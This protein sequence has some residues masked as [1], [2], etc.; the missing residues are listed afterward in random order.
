MKIVMD[1]GYLSSRLVCSIEE[2]KKCLGMIKVLDMW[3]HVIS[4]AG[5]LAL[6]RLTEYHS[7]DDFLRRAALAAIRDTDNIENILI[8]YLITGDY[9]GKEF[10]ECLLIADGF[11]LICKGVTTKELVEHLRGWF[12]ADF[13]E[14]YD[15]EMKEFCNY[16]ELGQTR[17]SI[18][19]EF[20][21]LL[22][23]SEDSFVALCDSITE[24][25]DLEDVALALKGTN[26]QI[27]DR[28]HSN[29]TGYRKTIID[30]YTRLLNNVRRIDVEWAQERIIQKGEFLGFIEAEK[31][32]E[33]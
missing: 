13:S 6:E 5:L 27:C 4:G 12:G 25:D 11:P 3:N 16:Q 20:D 21:K 2:K 23:L 33:E 26:E 8:Q 31:D 14:I 1:A 15:S 7:T 24:E 30:I 19:P 17:P 29:I 18:Y 9:H 10:L 28:F 32:E 22:N